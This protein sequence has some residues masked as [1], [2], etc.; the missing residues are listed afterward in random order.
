MGASFTVIVKSLVSDI[1]MPPIGL[2]FGDASLAD[3][4]VVLKDGEVAGPYLT[5]ADAR[6]AGAVTMNYG[7]FIDAVIAFLAVA[8]VLFVIV[9]YSR[10]M[11]EKNKKEAPP[12]A[13]ATKKCPHCMSDVNIGATRCAFCTSQIAAAA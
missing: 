7:T 2:L 11:T 4:F 13:P 3:R 6:A 5:L 10:K 1:L 9:R 8:F 12:A